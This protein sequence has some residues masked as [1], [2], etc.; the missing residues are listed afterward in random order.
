L[1]SKQQHSLHP[2]GVYQP[3]RGGAGLHRGYRGGGQDGRRRLSS[4][5]EPALQKSF[6]AGR[7]RCHRRAGR[8][9]TTGEMVLG[10]PA[11]SI[12]TA[13][14]FGVVDLPMPGSPQERQRPD[15]CEVGRARA[16]D[17]INLRPDKT[18]LSTGAA[19]ATRTRDPIITN[20]QISLS[21]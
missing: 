21:L 5:D 9:S 11:V 4:A 3:F 6:G 15:L 8:W 13:S 17:P 18:W 12:R 20:A 14:A 2:P 1:A 19:C 16:E 7:F 10:S